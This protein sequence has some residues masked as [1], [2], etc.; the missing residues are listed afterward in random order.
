MK[1][2]P[3]IGIFLALLTC[4]LSTLSAAEG[5]GWISL[6]DGK[7]LS[8]WKANEAQE[9][10]TVEDGCI[11]VNGPFSHLFYLGPDGNATFSDFELKVEMKAGP[12]TNSGIFFRVPAME[13]AGKYLNGAYEAQIQNDGKNDCYTG[14]LWIRAPRTDPSPVKPDEWFEVHIIA[15]GDKVTLKINGETTCEYSKAIEKQGWMSHPASGYIALQGHGP[16]HKPVFR[17]ISIK[18]INNKESSK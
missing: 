1:L 17:K 16:G 13:K 9:A 2:I 15:I 12:G 18:P 14:G 3:R 7:T 4:A 10:W 11:T 5:D 6:F 8:G